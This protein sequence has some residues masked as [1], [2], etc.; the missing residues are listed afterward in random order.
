[1]STQDRVEA[2]GK[3]L[4]GKAKEALGNITGDSKEKAEGQSKQVDAQ[5]Q[6]A[7]EDIKDKIK[8]VID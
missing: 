1:M 8:E 2:T 5:G 6:H 4:E 3:N 7:K